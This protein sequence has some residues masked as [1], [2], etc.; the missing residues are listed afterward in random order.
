M[1][2]KSFF[3]LNFVFLL[4]YGSSYSQNHPPVVTHVL[5][6]QRENNYLV[7]IQ[8]DVAD[9]DGDNLLIRVKI[10]DNG[11]LVTAPSISGDI[12]F[13]IVPGADKRITWNAGIDY[14]NRF[15]DYFVA[16]IEAYDASSDHSAYS[17]PFTVDT[18][19]DKPPV[20][21]WQVITDSGSTYNENLIIDHEGRIWCFYLRSTGSHQ[22]VYMKVMDS[23]GN[24]IKSE[25]VICHGSS[26]S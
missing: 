21:G 7:D 14:H 19:I 4:C 12:G 23:A 15:G 24:I 11:D 16:K 26:L 9:Q 2:F 25:Q 17:D 13:D 10:T 3:F 1:K 5:A 20:Q 18:R 22:P 6:Q 8:Y